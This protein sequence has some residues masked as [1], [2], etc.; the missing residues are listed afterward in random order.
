MCLEL[1]LKVIA[2]Q[3]GSV[4]KCGNGGV[5]VVLVTGKAGHPC[6]PAFL[7]PLD[8]SHFPIPDFRLQVNF[9]AAA[10][11]PSSPPLLHLPQTHGL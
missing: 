4:G 7:S 11:P 8:P 5:V 9:P 3:F 6:L 10:V 1:Q 2:E